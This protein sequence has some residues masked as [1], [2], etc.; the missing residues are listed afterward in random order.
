MKN[1]V[2]YTIFEGGALHTGK[3]DNKNPLHII[4][5]KH[6]INNVVELMSM[7]KKKDIFEVGCGEGQILGVLYQQGYK[8]S[9]LDYSEEAVKLSLQNFKRNNMDISVSKG[10]VYNCDDLPNGKMLI[11]LEVLE[12]LEKP[13]KA[14][15]ILCERT[16]EFL[17]VSVPR[18]PIW[19]I[20]NFFRGKYW[21]NFGNTPGHINH[22][23]KKKFLKLCKNY[24]EIV[25]VRS[26]FPWTIILLRKDK[27]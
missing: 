25:A 4:P 18:E 14:L 22:W 24:G 11:C 8:C 12:H 23:S 1:R 19:C 10:N 9:G 3:Y 21:K 17:L 13:E 16:D 27:R 20:L 15:Q 7:T 26:P 6:F 2:S 5:V